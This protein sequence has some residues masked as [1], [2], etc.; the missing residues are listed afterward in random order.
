MY[1]AQFPNAFA[2]QMQ[3]SPQDLGSQAANEAARSL[4]ERGFVVEA[5]ITP[6]LAGAIGQMA[7][8]PHIVE[9]CPNDATRFGT[10][11]AVRRWIGKN[12]GPQV[13]AISK[14][15]E[16]GDRRPIGWGWEGMGDT[17]E[18]P[19]HPITFAVRLGEEGLKQGLA[20]P[21]TI[22]IVAGS[23]A[24]SGADPRNVGLET[25]GSNKA[26]GVYEKAGFV[27][28]TTKDDVRPTLQPVGT[29]I[30][31]K[32]VVAGKYKGKP[33]NLVADVRHY[34]AYQGDLAPAA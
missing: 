19:D 30:N 10:E 6:Y 28:V 16:N 20:V 1:M 3:L 13:L 24:L 14:I 22:L 31:G 26:V 17:E 29:V 7:T 12:G 4:A 21:F 11:P 8:Q 33:A 23:A 5:G 2:E 25:W 27:P 9:Y 32:T 15:Q 34:M 18:L